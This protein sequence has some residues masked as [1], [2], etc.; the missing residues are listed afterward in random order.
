M[1]RSIVVLF[2]ASLF[3]LLYLLGCDKSSDMATQSPSP[4]PQEDQAAMTTIISQDAL[5]TNDAAVLEDGAPPLAKGSTAIV[6]RNWGRKIESTSRNVTY[7]K[8]NDSIVIATVTNTLSGQIWIRVKRT[9][10]DTVIYKPLLETMMHRVIFMR[11]AQTNHPRLN[12]K[13]YAVS[14]SQGGTGNGGII[15]QNVTF[16]IGEDTI[17]ITNPLDSLFQ[18][19]PRH[20]RWCLHEMPQNST[21]T[22]KIQVTVK[23]TDPDS[24]IV[25]AHRPIWFMSFSLYRRAPMNLVSVDSSG[26]IYTRVYEH[27][28]QGVGPGRHHVMVGAITRQ[29]I[30]DDQAPF[31][32][33]IWG[34]PYIVNEN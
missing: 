4:V 9:L 10:K 15:I 20:G 30:Y 23:S 27:T 5:F 12:W 34:I 6:P 25:V 32:S 22:F 26:G 8:I 7:D 28:W 31:S 3:F 19:G 13:I 24:D 16:F 1:K 2:G 11:V 21:D 14:A 17:Q 18:V 29:S 33:Q